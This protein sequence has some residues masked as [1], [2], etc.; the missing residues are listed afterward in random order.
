MKNE[1]T[2]EEIQNVRTALNADI[3]LDPMHRQPEVAKRAVE[4]L[5]FLLEEIRGLNE[6]IQTRDNQISA[7][8][9]VHGQ[10]SKE[11]ERVTLLEDAI[12]C[13]EGHAWENCTAATHSTIRNLGATVGVQL[14]SR[15]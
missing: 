1:H 14:D 8:K 7:A 13:I 11:L 6:V 3:T 12:R 9:E 2:I 5:D 4:V 15:S 10:M